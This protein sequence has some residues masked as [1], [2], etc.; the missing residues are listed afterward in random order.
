[1]PL[2]NFIALL[3]ALPLIAHASCPSC[4]CV[5][6]T[7]PVNFGNSYNPLAGN[8]DDTLG[9][10]IAT[11]TSLTPIVNASFSLAL[12]P[13]MNTGFNPRLLESGLNQL[14][15]NLYTNGSYTQIWGD[16][17]NGTNTVTFSNCSSTQSLPPYSC[18]YTFTVYGKIPPEQLSVVG[19]QTY[20]NMI[21]ATLTY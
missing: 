6:T 2:K 4:T 21:T 11:C 20:T 19:N 14:D 13:G 9:S 1:M 7:T 8:V 12:N 10:V 3:F 16:S 15:Y 17:T 18:S 5:L